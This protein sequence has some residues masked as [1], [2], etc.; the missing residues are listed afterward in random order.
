MSQMPRAR[1]TN[2]QASAV[3]VRRRCGA[4][5]K[6]TAEVVDRIIEA[7]AAGNFLKTSA[8]LA[9]IGESTFHKHRAIGERD[10]EEGRDTLQAQFVKRLRRAE[11][12]GEI[13]HIAVIA[14]AAKGVKETRVRW[15]VRQVLRGGEPVVITD[16]RGQPALDPEGKVQYLEFVETSVKT[17]VRRDWRASAFLLRYRH[18]SRW[19]RHGQRR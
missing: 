11:A 8:A 3:H 15:R 17:T 1:T 2:R 7:V 12:E 14:A 18:P 6:F 4:P 10:L 13:K 5:S 9:G 19:G 16:A